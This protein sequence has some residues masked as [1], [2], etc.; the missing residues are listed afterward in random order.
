WMVDPGMNPSGAGEDPKYYYTCPEQTR[1]SY[2]S[3][4][5]RV[6]LVDTETRSIIDTLVVNS[7]EGDESLIEDDGETSGCDPDDDILDIPY[8]IRKGHWYKV[9]DSAPENE[10]V[11]PQIMWLKDYNGDGKALEFALFN[12]EACVGLTT[13][14]VG[15][16]EWQD[17]VIQYQIHLDVEDD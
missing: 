16:S 10:E 13:T 15:Y 9:E 14:L 11:K 12:K 1:G 8:A 4:P 3:G 2:Y 6:S 17:K 7:A 5:T